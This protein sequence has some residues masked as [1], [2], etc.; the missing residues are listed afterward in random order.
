LWLI[1]IMTDIP[2]TVF[3]FLAFFLCIPPA[4]FNYKVSSRPWAT[5]ILVG[6]IMINNLCFSIDSIIWASPDVDSR[7][8][9]YGWCDIDARLKDMFV[10]G[11]PGSAVGICRFLA[12][13]TNPDPAQKDLQCHRKRRNLIDLF[14]GFGSLSS[15]RRS[16]SSLPYCGRQ[17]M[18][19]HHRIFLAGPLSLPYL[20]STPLCRGGWLFLYP[21]SP[22]SGLIVVL[23]IR[24]WWVRR[25][26][27][28]AGVHNGISKGDFQRLMLTV[29]CVIF[30]YLPLSFLG[31]ATFLVAPK[32]PF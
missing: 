20:G 31:L 25:K 5:L 22:E 32:V 2:F 13:A 16:S 30:V 3:S 7:W 28:N 12:D 27:M 19:R 8:P 17:W 4:Y 6:W 24:H 11:V 29:L 9:G 23:F 1:E 26:R 18:R 21:P 14:L 10:I 15:F